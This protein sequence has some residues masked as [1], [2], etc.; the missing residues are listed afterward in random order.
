MISIEIKK[1]YKGK[2]KVKCI[3]YNLAYAISLDKFILFC[4]IKIEFSFFFSWFDIFALNK[5]KKNKKDQIF[6]VSKLK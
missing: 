6:L 2:R 1:L 3:I 5:K 4:S